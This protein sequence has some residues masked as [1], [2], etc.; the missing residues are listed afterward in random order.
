MAITQLKVNGVMGFVSGSYAGKE[1][2]VSIAYVYPLSHY[3][4]KD[5]EIIHYIVKT[6]NITVYR[7]G[8]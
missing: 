1:Q 4:I 5:V 3:V 8:S 6:K 7:S 2:V